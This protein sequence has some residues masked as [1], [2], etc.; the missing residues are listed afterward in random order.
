MTDVKYSQRQQPLILN[1][2]FFFFF[3]LP[4]PNE[5]ECQNKAASKKSPAPLVSRDNI[6]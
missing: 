5:D 3:F 6:F 2:G 4:H 1:M